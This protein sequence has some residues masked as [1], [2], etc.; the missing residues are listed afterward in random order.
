MKIRPVFLSG[1]GFSLCGL[2]FARTKTAQAE[3]YGT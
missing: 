2:E 1:K 3:A